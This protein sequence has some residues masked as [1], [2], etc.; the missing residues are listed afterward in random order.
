MGQTDHR[1]SYKQTRQARPCV[2]DSVLYHGQCITEDNRF[3]PLDPGD[4]S[5]FEIPQALFTTNQ[6][7]K[8]WTPCPQAQF[9]KDSHYT[10]YENLGFHQSLKITVPSLSTDKGIGQ[11]F[12]AA[13]L[14]RLLKEPKTFPS[15]R[16]LKRDSKRDTFG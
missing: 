16:K 5:A 14:Q 15:P 8:G 11:L 7:A 2:T 13:F 3:P 4:S 9:P 6:V 10:V 12:P 1:H